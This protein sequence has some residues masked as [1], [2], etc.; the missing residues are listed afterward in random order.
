MGRE[1]NEERTAMPGD[2]MCLAYRTI[3]YI[4]R[5][6]QK[7]KKQRSNTSENDES[8]RVNQSKPNQVAEEKKAQWSLRWFGVIQ[9]RGVLFVRASVRGEKKSSSGLASK[10]DPPFFEKAKK[11]GGGCVK[12]EKKGGKNKLERR[13]KRRKETRR[14]KYREIE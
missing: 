5:K 6:F 14:K 9:K 11:K 8:I 3:V 7:K 2:G 12:E 1:I 4:L 13:V 10:K